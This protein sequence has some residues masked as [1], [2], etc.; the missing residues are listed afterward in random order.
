MRSMGSKS[1]IKTNRSA[2]KRF[3]IRGS[4]SIKRNKAGRQ[5]NTGYKTRGRSNRLGQS[6]GVKGKEIEKRM[7]RLVAN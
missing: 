5:H 4:G 3:R 1:C 2:A 7:R 6:A